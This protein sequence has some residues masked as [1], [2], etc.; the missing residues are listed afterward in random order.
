ML[1]EKHLILAMIFIF[2]YSRIDLFP[3]ENWKTGYID[4]GDNANSLYYYLFR[5]RNESISRPPL[6]IWLEGG[7]GI[8]SA[9]GVWAEAGPYI[10]NNKTKKVE[11]SPF[12]WNNYSDMLF[13]DQPAGVPFSI[14]NDLNKMCKNL[15]CVALQFVSFLTRFYECYPEY[16]GR[17]L[18]VGGIS[19]GGHYV[20][21]IVGYLMKNPNRDINLK[22]M[23]IANGLISIMVQLPFYPVFLYENN[24]IG[25]VVSYWFYQSWTLTC[26]IAISLK[27]DALDFPCSYMFNIFNNIGLTND[28]YIFKKKEEKYTGLLL[29]I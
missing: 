28:P 14:S 4:L 16:K 24:L 1:Q 6:V 26:R 29:E 15:S 10:Q 5:C 12:A 9:L 23:L 2:C 22:G 25:I 19:Y 17:D 20:P 3:G 11:W 8:S 7:P 13:V 21:A 27:I 18:Y